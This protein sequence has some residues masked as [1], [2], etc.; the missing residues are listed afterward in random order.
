MANERQRIDKKQ[1]NPRRFSVISFKT[2]TAICL[3][4]TL[5]MAQ[6][7]NISGV[8]QDN[9]GVGVVGA[10]VKLEKA[11]IAATSGA[12][13]AFALIGS[14]SSTKPPTALS[15]KAAK[16]VQLRNGKIEFTLS[17]NTTVAISMYDVGGRQRFSSKRTLGSGTYSI[18]VPMQ[19]MGIFLCKVTIGNEAYSFKGSSF[20][21]SSTEQAV[22]SCRT[23]TLARQ[24]KATAVISD[25][26]AATSP[27]MLNYRCVI[28][29]SDTSGVVIKMIAN[30]G[31]MT[32]ADGN[33]YQSVRIGSQVWMAENLRV[34]KYNDGTPISHVPDSAAWHNLYIPGSTT[35]AYCYYNNTTNADSIKKYG[36]LYNWHVVGS[37]NPKK[38]APTGWHVPSYAEWDTLYNC[39]IA[40]GYNWDGTR[41]GNKIAKSMATKTDWKRCVQTGAIG[42]DLSK[43]NASGFSALPAGYR[44]P[45]C[46]FHLQSLTGFWWSATERDASNGRSRNLFYVVVGLYTSYNEKETCGFSVRLLRD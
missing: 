18:N 41:T 25:V 28:E 46:N 34:T 15:A 2:V 11:N 31:D 26:I 35:G 7:I 1:S 17:G 13:G 38:I 9:A 20:R 43:N 23:S 37:S 24:A 6:T 32:D 39:L 22:V 42:N 45:D 44:L 30:A 19:A 40:N 33:V 16:P 27:G 4:A 36:A 3:G 5:C 10:T 14:I 21:A 8:V 29:N 12:G